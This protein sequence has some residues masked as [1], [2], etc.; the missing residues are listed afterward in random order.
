MEAIL[1]GTRS[2]KLL[3]AQSNQTMVVGAGDGYQV[4]QLK[5][6]CPYLLVEVETSFSWI[7]YL[8]IIS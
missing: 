4:E 8:F 2:L 6:N 3:H 1:E 5:Y 7:I